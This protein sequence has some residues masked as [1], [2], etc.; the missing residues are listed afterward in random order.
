MAILL[1]GG[2]GH[3]GSW[4]C[5]EAARQERNVIVTDRSRR[6]LNYLEDLEDYIEFESADL[7]DHASICRIFKEHE[8]E[9]EGIIHV[10]G[11]MGGPYFAAEPR[12]HVR[13]NTMGTVDML[14]AARI[15][16]VS[17][18]VYLS[19]GAVYG[20]REDIPSETDPM[21]PGD[22]YGAAKASAEFFGL[23]YANEFGVDF[24]SIRVYFAYGPGRL[25]SELYPL[26]QA[27]FGCLQ[28]RTKI[29][30]PAGAD[31]V[32]DFTY[33]KDIA[34]AVLLVYDAPKPQYRQYNATS[35]VCHRLPELIEK[36]SRIA[37][38]PVSVH[39]GPGKV[40]P[41]GPSLDSRRLRE[42][43]GFAPEYD[44]D[45][46]VNEYLDWIRQEG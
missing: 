14:E 30:L 4:V 15:F 25:P 39:V 33:I 19:S 40:M 21:A 37:G 6:R 29:E 28:G 22:L 2:F 10:G 27:V 31:Q 23:Q 3:I 42:E 18:F 26:Y 45:K 43:L 5:Y 8:G 38:R 44:L 11:L 41:R 36:V 17:K 9:I 32:I 24:R 35:G 12:H 13:I 20:P 34:R 7:L 46:G 1:T 16:G